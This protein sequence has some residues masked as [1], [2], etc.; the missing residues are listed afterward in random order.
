[1]TEK[2]HI[3]LIQDGR[4]S[5][6]NSNPGHVEAG[7]LTNQPRRFMLSCRLHVII[8]YLS[9]NMWPK[10]VHTVSSIEHIYDGSWPGYVPLLYMSRIPVTKTPRPCGSPANHKLRA[11][12]RRR[13]A[14]THQPRARTEVSHLHPDPAKAP[15]GRGHRCITMAT[16][17]CL[18][19]H[20]A[21]K[22]MC[23]LVLMLG[24][25]DPIC[26]LWCALLHC[27]AK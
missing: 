19:Y 18:G 26:M 6:Q 7:I 8:S 13:R 23:Y 14:A 15:E 11:F 24:C 4:S 16:N 12:V 1:V 27:L 5:C 9:L 2:N 22:W 3:K 20:W 21:G 10:V 25:C 17:L